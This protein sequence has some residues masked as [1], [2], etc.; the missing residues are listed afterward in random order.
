MSAGAAGDQRR[1]LGDSIADY[2]RRSD[3][4]RRVRALRDTEPGFDRAAWQDMADLGW[5]GVMVPEADGGLG[6]SIADY[7]VVAR[8]VGAALVPEPLTGALLA[9]C[10]LVESPS[11]EL[12]SSLLTGFVSGEILPALAWQEAMGDV[13]PAVVATLADARNGEVVLSGYKRF[14]MGAAGADGLVVSARDDEGLALYWVPRSSP[15]LSLTTRPLADGRCVSDVLFEATTIAKSNRLVSGEAAS[16]A[17]TT[18]IDNG[19]LAISAE[20]LGVSQRTLDMTLDYLRTRSQFGK[21]IGAFQAL[22]H[23][24]VDLYIHRRIAEATFDH[25]LRIVE[26]SDDV[27]LRSTAASRAKARTSESARRITREA[28][29]MHGA[30]GFTDDCDIGLYVKRALVLCAWLGN[31]AWHRR[32]YAAL[33]PLETV[34]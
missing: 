27:E 12:R 30:I 17:L 11:G 2:C 20:L 13:D 16:R 3:P 34:L 10:A 15:N 6:L 9:T 19:N 22:Q 26:A 33:A 8:G 21:P 4:V 14:V 1:M 23:R 31:A 7:A 28:I 25:A 18:A 32:R 29:Q 24:A 5:L